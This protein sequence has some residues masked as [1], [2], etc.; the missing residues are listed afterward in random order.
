MQQPTYMDQAVELGHSGD[1]HTCL[2]NCSWPER[3]A[4]VRYPLPLS[5]SELRVVQRSSQGPHLTCPKRWY[6]PQR[7]TKS[8]HCSPWAV[9]GVRLGPGGGWTGDVAGSTPVLPTSSGSIC[10]RHLPGI[11][12]CLQAHLMVLMSHTP[13]L[14]KTWAGDRWPAHS[15]WHLPSSGGSAKIQLV[16]GHGG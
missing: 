6:M 9:V 10:S 5:V 8:R 1:C 13:E 15:C 11:P 14:M 7:V 16:R 3:V 2:C 4:G 12:P